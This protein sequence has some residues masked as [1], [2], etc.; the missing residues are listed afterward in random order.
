LSS[1]TVAD[2]AGPQAVFSV[3]A[4]VTDVDQVVYFY[5]YSVGAISWNW[6]FGDGNTSVLQNPTNTYSTPGN[7]DVWLYVEDNFGCRDS[8]TQ[9]ILVNNVFTIHIPNSFSPNG[10]GIND[11][12]KPIGIRIDVE[13]YLMQ[14]FDRWG[15]KIFE[16]TDLNK[17]WDGSVN[18]KSIAD[19]DIMNATF[20]YYI[21]V[22]EEGTDADHEYR[23]G[24]N[25]IR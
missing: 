21:Y 23:G 9:N 5:D 22:V 3:S 18:G 15:K 16:T 20:V 17:G 7:Y 13:N 1:I 4:T 12:F 2:L 8:T 6:T 25:L 24:V 11:V 19:K 10:D 14:I